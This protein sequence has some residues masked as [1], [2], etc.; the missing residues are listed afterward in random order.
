MKKALSVIIVSI[1]CLSMFV[2]ALTMMSARAVVNVNVTFDQQGVTSLYSGTVVSVD[3][4]AYNV[5]QLP[6]TFSWPV[7][8]MH[9]FTYASPLVVNDT[10]GYTWWNTT[11]LDTEQS[12]NTFT[13]SVDGFVNATYGLIGDFGHY[14]TVN[15]ADLVIFAIAFNT[16]PVNV[17]WNS[18]CDLANQ[19]V[20]NLVDL[21]TFAMHYNDHY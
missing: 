4:V 20:I 5:T 12:N 9:N 3:A 8:S 18:Q 19:G 17:N 2:S 13:A 7:G 16:Q 1:L 21:V 6:V 15:L 11:G 10:Y 14:G